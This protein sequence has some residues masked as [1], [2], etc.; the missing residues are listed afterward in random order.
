MY[1]LALLPGINDSISV[2]QLLDIVGIPSLFD[3][4]RTF[5]GLSNLSNSLS[6][7]HVVVGWTSG[8]KPDNLRFTVTLDEWSL[9]ENIFEV[10]QISVD[11]EAMNLTSDTDRVFALNGWGLVKIAQI[12]VE[13]FFA[14]THSSDDNVSDQIYFQVGTQQRAIPLGSIIL[15]LLG[16]ETIL[17][18]SL[19]S[20]LE[21]T[22]MDNFIVKAEKTGG[23][24]SVSKIQISISVKKTIELLGMVFPSRILIC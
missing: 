24:W 11:I 20:V 18:D 8:P 1:E 12:D 23:K 15:H 9:A 3:L 6:I 4:S 17:P 16:D 2:G 5:S 10:S 19:S 7:S 22:V 21:E 14:Y 13:V